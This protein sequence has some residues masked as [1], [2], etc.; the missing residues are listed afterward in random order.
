M[1][2]QYDC[3]NDTPYLYSSKELRKM[4]KN[5]NG[6]KE[7]NAIVEH[8]ERHEV[9]NN[10]EYKG[11]YRLSNDIMDALYEEEDEILDW[12]EVIDQ[13]QPVMTSNGLR[14]KRKEGFR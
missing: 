7:T 4:Y 2:W 5:S 8:M 11:Y 13:Y 1:R 14:L 12:Q 10:R 3:L 9:Y 6:K